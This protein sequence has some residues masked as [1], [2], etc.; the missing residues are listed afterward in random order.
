MFL[1]NVK[2]LLHYATKYKGQKSKLEWENGSQLESTF[3]FVAIT[4]RWCIGVKLYEK[5][6]YHYLQ[7]SNVHL[8]QILFC[9]MNQLAY[10]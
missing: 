7:V 3:F 9:I 8:D 4:L 2:P 10:V 1:V 6:V 5:H